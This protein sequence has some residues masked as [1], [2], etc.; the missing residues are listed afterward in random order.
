MIM[1]KNDLTEEYIRV[2]IRYYKVV[3]NII[4]GVRQKEI[5]PWSLQIIRED[6]PKRWLR[7]MIIK[8]Y[9]KFVV[10]PDNINYHSEID[11][12]YNMYSQV[13]HKPSKGDCK[14]ILD[15]IRH[16]FGEQYEMGL[17]YLELLYTQPKQRLPILLLVSKE[18]ATGKTTFTNF[19]ADL[20]Q[21][22]VTFNTNESF[23]SPFNSDWASKLIIVVDE[24]FMNKRSDYEMIKNKSTAQ[25][26]KI[27]LKGVDR[28]E[29][30]F[31]GKIIMCSNDENCPIAIEK[32]ENR[33][34]VR[35]VPVLEKDVPNIAEQL[36]KEIPAFLYFLLN[37]TIS[38]PKCSRMWFSY[39]DI[40]TE[41]LK[42]IIN[43][44]IDSSECDLFEFLYDIMDDFEKEDICFSVA[45]I[46]PL[47]KREC[48]SI[49]RAEIKRILKKYGFKKDNTAYYAPIIGKNGAITFAKKRSGRFYIV[50]KTMASEIVHL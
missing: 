10:V 29:I 3:N 50:S 26:I 28:I 9:D 5:I 23:R 17:D 27:E 14:T 19:I 12:G 15:L 35:K 8:K 36:H 13:S 39:S 46:L 30:P 49:D 44:N 40:E 16:I 38:K 34:W 48:I 18:R 20:F 22:N 2:G 4:G 42:K 41:A 31:F 11:G 47:L 32:G 45:D 37:R 33:F 6:F 25:S 24:A 7:E 1:G 21:S 43:Y